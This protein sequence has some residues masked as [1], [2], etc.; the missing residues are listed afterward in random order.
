M[1][2]CANLSLGFMCLVR[3]DGGCY[4]IT[5]LENVEVSKYSMYAIKVPQMVTLGKKSCCRG[6]LGATGPGWLV[7]VKKTRGVKILFIHKTL[8]Q[9]HMIW[10]QVMGD[11]L[12]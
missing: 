6:I 2:W 3:Y 12:L 9:R 10:S 11:M 8:R 7:Y 5:F 4:L 1:Q